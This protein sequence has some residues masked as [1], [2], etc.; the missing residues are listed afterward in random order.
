MAGAAAERYVIRRPLGRGG[1]GTVYAARDDG[2]GA[3][4]RS[5][6]RTRRRRSSDLDRGCARRRACSRD[7]EHP[8]I[9]PVHDAG[10]LDDGRWFY[11]MKCVR[12]ETLPSTCAA[13]AGEAAVLGVFERI[14]ETVAFAHA[15]GVVH[16]DL[17]PSNVMVG[18][19][20]RCWCSTGA[21]PRCSRARRRRRPRARAPPLGTRTSRGRDAGTRIGTPGFMAPEQARA[22]REGRTGGRRLRARRAAL[23]AADGDAR[24]PASRRV[25]R[26]LRAARPRRQTPRARSSPSAVARARRPLRQRRGGWSPISRA[27]APAWP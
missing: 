2:S 14:A 6:S 12:G 19:S 22:T 10:L 8:G 26:R 24:R 11:V 27:I 15:A 1:M 16:R 18:R 23:L 4:S 9:V 7:L 3:R 17:K 25:S 13:L 21:S 20:A 5:R